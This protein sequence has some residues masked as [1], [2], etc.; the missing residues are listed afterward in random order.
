MVVLIKEIKP[1]RFRE[2]VFNR[3]L[4]NALRRVG[5]RLKKDFEGTTATWEHQPKFVVKSH[6]TKQL[7]SPSVEVYTEDEIYRYVNEGT[8]PHDIWAG[9]YTGKSEAKT[10]AFPSMFIPK[11]TPGSLEVDYGASGGETVFTPYVRHPGTKARKFDQQIKEKREK[12]FRNQM[13][14]AMRTAARKS[15]HPA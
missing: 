8:R 6:L 4:R 3:E 14:E 7:P 11:T 13:H 15:G 12:W 10:L 2:E 5:Y 9:A 1:Q